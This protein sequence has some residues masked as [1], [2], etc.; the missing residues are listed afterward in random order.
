MLGR[1]MLYPA[2]QPRLAGS[3]SDTEQ[4]RQQWLE[5]RE[6]LELAIAG[7]PDEEIQRAHRLVVWSHNEYRNAKQRDRRRTG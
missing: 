3:M 4:L 2:V 1:S 5:K 6:E 7:A